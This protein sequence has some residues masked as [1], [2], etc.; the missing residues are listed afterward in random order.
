LGILSTLLNEGCSL[1]IRNDI[2][3]YRQTF[4]PVLDYAS[5]DLCY[6]YT[7][8]QVAGGKAKGFRICSKSHFYAGN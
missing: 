3:P 6:V 1:S 7:C 8:E 5:L 4:G 2:M